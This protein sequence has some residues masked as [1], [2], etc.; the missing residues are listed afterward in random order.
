MPVLTSAPSLKSH[1]IAGSHFGF[2]ATR[3]QDLGA[4]EFTLAVIAAD[5]SGSVGGFIRDIE[6]CVGTVVKACGRSPRAD[7]LLLRVTRFDSSLHEVHGFKPLTEIDPQDYAQSMKAGGMT[8]LH[9]A[10]HNAVASVTSY[11]ATLTAHDFDVNGIVF[12]ITDGAD[13]HSVHSAAE[14]KQALRDAVAGEQIESMISVLVGVNMADAGLADQLKRYAA[15]AGFTEFVPLE[16]AR[17]ATLA[18]L[19][20]FV[21]RSISLQSRSLGSGG[22]ASLSF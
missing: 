6:A 13:N 20:D 3:L 5:N 19:A 16:D 11:G 10:A 12:V 8:A 4:S 2:S 18:K 22:A 17:E 21:S 9:D 14:V 1:R 15:D 7:N